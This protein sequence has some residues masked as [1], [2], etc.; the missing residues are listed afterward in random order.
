MNV[1]PEKYQHVIRKAKAGTEG[2]VNFTDDLICHGK[3]VLE[4]DQRLHKL[5]AKLEENNLTLKGEKCTFRMNSLYENSPFSAWCWPYGGESAGRE[6][7]QSSN[8]TFR[9][10][11]LSWVGWIQLQVYSRLCHYRR[12]PK[13]TYQEWSQV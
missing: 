9:G 6:G 13:S 10:E 5:L 2:V 12:T 4:H 3:I 7:R 1:A 11:E 8:Y